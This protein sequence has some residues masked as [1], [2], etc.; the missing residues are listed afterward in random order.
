[1]TRPLW[2]FQVGG[3]IKFLA[4]LL[5]VPAVCWVIGWLARQ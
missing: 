4:L 5:L 3:Q 1:M 2:S